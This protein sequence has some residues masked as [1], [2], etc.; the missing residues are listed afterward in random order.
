MLTAALNEHCRTTGQP[1]TA[2]R[3]AGQLLTAAHIA[4]ATHTAHTAWIK[5]PHT[6]H[7]I[8]H[9]ALLAHTAIDMNWNSS[10]WMRMYLWKIM[11][12]Y[13][14]YYDE[15]IRRIKTNSFK[16]TW[17]YMNI[18]MNIFQIIWFI[19]NLCQM[20]QIRSELIW[21]MLTAALNAHCRI[22]GQPLTAVHIATAAHTAHTAWI[23]VP[24]TTHH[25]YTAH[26]TS[27][28]HRN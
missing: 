22:A 5:V 20:K 9:T 7:H 23:K 15:F 16:C 27:V 18:D 12:I 13:V 2:A 8:P 28:T 11:W 25:I 21:N 6:T 3:T 14:N 4:T 24:H 1:H 19:P 10:L 17:I 26:C